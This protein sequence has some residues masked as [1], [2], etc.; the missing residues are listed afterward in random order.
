[1]SVLKSESSSL[2]TFERFKL[3]QH[4]WERGQRKHRSNQVCCLWTGNSQLRKKNVYKGFKRHRHLLWILMEQ[5]PTTQNCRRHR[6]KQTCDL[7]KQPVTRNRS[8]ASFNI[9]LKHKGLQPRL[10]YRPAHAAEF[11]HKTGQPWILAHT[12]PVGTK[13][14]PLPAQRWTKLI[15]KIVF[16]SQFLWCTLHQHHLLWFSSADLTI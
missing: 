6:P 16:A 12:V 11:P 9:I 14:L 10:S 3:N 1:M 7:W 4:E 13:F 15:T 8:Q 5:S 2:F